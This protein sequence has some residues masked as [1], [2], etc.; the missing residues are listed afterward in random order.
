L[1]DWVKLAGY[2]NDLDVLPE[3]L[4]TRLKH[5]Q[6]KFNEFANSLRDGI[7]LCNLLNAI[8]PGSI[9]TSQIVLR[10]AQTSQLM[11]LKNINLFLF[12]CK[13]KFNLAQ[14]DLFEAHMLYNLDIECVIKA[15]STLSK[16]KLA[17]SSSGR[18]GFSITE[19]LDD[20]SI[21]DIYYNVQQP[22]GLGVSSLETEEE[23][24]YTPDS[25]IICDTSNEQ[26]ENIYQAI[27]NK[28]PVGGQGLGKNITKKDHVIKEIYESESKFVN[29]LTIIVIDFL[30][31]L[32]SQLSDKDRQC[33]FI[34]IEI[35]KELH[36]TLFNKLR[37][38]C[39]GG[40]GRTSRICI[41]FDSF[42]QSMMREYVD[43]FA[44][45]QAAISKVDS[46]MVKGD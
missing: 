12:A 10:R 27:I 19:T 31:P 42:K 37:D 24:Y 18:P 26:Q 43:Y 3:P 5:N 22:S 34:N 8:A 45:M 39:Q 35:L 41:V 2:L 7:I 17:E 29:T 6:L 28:A 4:K 44:G 16:T 21:N 33:I 13:Q 20:S 38:A 40:H 46:L 36:S 9:D 1:S 23:S 30:K 15:L 25:F 14:Q 11:C 32:Y